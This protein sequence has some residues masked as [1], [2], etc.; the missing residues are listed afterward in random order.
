MSLLAQPYFSSRDSV[1]AIAAAE[2]I[3]SMS[4]SKKEVFCFMG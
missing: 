4:S 1:R 3:S 2:A